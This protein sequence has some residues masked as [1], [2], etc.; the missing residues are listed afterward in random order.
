[1]SFIEGNIIERDVLCSG[2]IDLL[3]LI[4]LSNNS[5][6]KIPCDEETGGSLIKLAKKAPHERGE[7]TVLDKNVQ[8]AW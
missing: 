3:P 8:D 1:M 7:K 5:F 4:K 6:L 2:A